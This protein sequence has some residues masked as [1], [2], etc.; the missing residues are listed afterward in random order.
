MLISLQHVGSHDY[1]RWLFPF[2]HWGDFCGQPDVWTLRSPLCAIAGYT[3]GR[4][5]VARVPI[6]EVGNKFNVNGEL[7]C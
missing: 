3:Q 1:E 6:L 7:H 4:V 5:A 2:S